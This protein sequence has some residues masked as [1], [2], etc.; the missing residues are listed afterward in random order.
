MTLVPV[1]PVVAEMA[2]QAGLGPP[3]RVF[4]AY[5]LVRVARQ[6]VY[7]FE[8]GGVFLDGDAISR[9]EDPRMGKTL[10]VR[11]ADVV[12]FHQEITRVRGPAGVHVEY[13]YRFR[14][15]D[16]AE[17]QLSARTFS[18]LPSGL[19]EFTAVVDPLI[20]AAQ[21]AGMLEALEQGRPVDFGCLTVEPD[22]IRK[23]REKLPWTA[24]DTIDGGHG[25]GRTLVVREKGR[26]P[27]G[28]HWALPGL[29]NRSAF[30]AL[31]RLNG[32]TV[33]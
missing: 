9:P 30:L 2:A 8:D 12:A 14:F 27:A 15:A 1:P 4:S 32:V 24:V 17:H 26:R 21:L 29:A 6:D 16:G 19:E 7:V 13:D 25:P 18:R 5:R 31:A 33:G 22:G 11:W 23:G 20:T 28:A 10:C 3:V